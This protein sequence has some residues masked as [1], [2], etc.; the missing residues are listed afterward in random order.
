[1]VRTAPHA[2]SDDVRSQDAA[3]FDRI[4]DM[5]AIQNGWSWP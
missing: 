5:G 1:L 2:A 3:K 4:T